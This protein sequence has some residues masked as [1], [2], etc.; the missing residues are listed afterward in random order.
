MTTQQIEERLAMTQAYQSIEKLIHKTIWDFMRKYGGDYDDLLSVCHE[1]F[2]F[3]YNKHENKRAK[4][5]TWVQRI[6]WQRMTQHSIREKRRKQ[7]QHHIPVEDLGLPSSLAPSDYNKILENLSCDAWQIALAILIIPNTTLFAS[8]IEERRPYKLRRAARN[9][10]YCSG[11]CEAR[12]NNAV[13][14]IKS[15]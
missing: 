9:M 4:L 1:A 13:A 6:I 14:E 5:T 2:V 12:W 11:W 7:N 10:F 3:A 8:K 15:V